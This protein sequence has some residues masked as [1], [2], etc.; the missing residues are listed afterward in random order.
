MSPAR[1]RMEKT[2]SFKARDEQGATC[3]VDEFTEFDAANPHEVATGRKLYALR[4]GERLYARNLTE[5]ESGW[6][7]KVTL[8]DR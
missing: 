1:T 7:Q 4:T 3:W 8:V 5:F 6:G 2:N